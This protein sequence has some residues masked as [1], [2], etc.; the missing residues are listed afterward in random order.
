[1]EQVLL[2]VRKTVDQTTLRPGDIVYEEPWIELAGD[3]RLTIEDVRTGVVVVADR[4]G[5]LYGMQLRGGVRMDEEGPRGIL[6]PL[7][8]RET[9]FATQSEALLAQARRERLEAETSIRLAEQLEALAAAF[10]ESSDAG[11]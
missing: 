10:E 11:R 1:M 4:D 2:S 8:A 7:D 5:V 9:L 6:H 3:R